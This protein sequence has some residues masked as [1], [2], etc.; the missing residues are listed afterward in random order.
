MNE[1]CRPAMAGIIGGSVPLIDFRRPL[2]ARRE[3]AAERVFSMALR[4]SSKGFALALRSRGT[5]LT[6]SSP[7][8]AHACGSKELLFFRRLNGTTESRA[9]I[10]NFRV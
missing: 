7:G 10:Q 1:R 9:L 5:A 8:Y 6:K 4:F 2:T 3:A